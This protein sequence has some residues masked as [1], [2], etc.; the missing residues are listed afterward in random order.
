MGE[1]VDVLMISSMIA[2]LFFMVRKYVES[3]VKK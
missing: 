3:R 1:V 2:I